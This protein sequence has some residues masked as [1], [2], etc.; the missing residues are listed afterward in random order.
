MDW[1]LFFLFTHDTAFGIL[2]ECDD[3]ADFGAVGHLFLNLIDDIEHTRL[4]VE[5]QTVGIGNVLL[6]LWVDLGIVHHGGVR[7]AILH[8]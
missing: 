8:G 4:T 1:G 7:T 3:V 5:Q 2:E 6:N